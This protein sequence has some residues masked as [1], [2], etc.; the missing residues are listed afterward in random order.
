MKNGTKGS[1]E[2]TGG[3]EAGGESTG[4][5]E[6]EG[7]EEAPEGRRRRRQEEEEDE[8]QRRDLQDIH[9]QGLEAGPPR[10]WDFQ[11][12]H[13]NHEQLH[14]RHLR[15]ARQRVVEARSLQ[16]EADDH[17]ARNPDGGAAGSSRR[18]RQ[19]RG[20]RRNQGGYQVY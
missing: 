5:E 1:G 16:Q 15:E 8:A 12:G 7:G 19:A 6:A 11:Q 14:Q 2:E 17:L 13:G 9:L 4:R 10:H 20:L 18:A 3:E